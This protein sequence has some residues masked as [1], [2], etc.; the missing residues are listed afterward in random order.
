MGRQKRG[1]AESSAN[2]SPGDTLEA[3]RRLCWK[4]GTRGGLGSHGRAGW[5]GGGQCVV[6][7]WAAPRR[8]RLPS[9]S[10]LAQLGLRRPSPDRAFCRV[11]PREPR[12]TL[13][14]PHQGSRAAEG[15][16][17]PA[18]RG[19]RRPEEEALTA[20]AGCC[21]GLRWDAGA[22]GAAQNQG[23][24]RYPRPS[25]HPTPACSVARRPGEAQ[26]QG[27]WK[28]GPFRKP[29]VPQG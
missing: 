21:K 15:A 25:P 29:T 5:V 27:T 16:A 26:L 9:P 13:T 3:K 6:R 7:S 23:K 12:A 24:L 18:G 1:S 10:P 28:K 11:S 14:L 22:A 20:G 2:Q 8:P 17:P 4:A 19:L